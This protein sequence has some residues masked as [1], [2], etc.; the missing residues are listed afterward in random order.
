MTERGMGR[1]SL[2]ARANFTPILALPHSRNSQHP[3]A[4]PP[5][6]TPRISPSYPRPLPPG[7]ISPPLSPTTAADPTG[8]RRQG[9]GRTDVPSRFGSR[10]A[11]EEV[12]RRP[13]LKSHR[14]ERGVSHHPLILGGAPRSPSAG[15]LSGWPE[16][17]LLGLFGQSAKERPPAASDQPGPRGCRKS[18]LGLESGG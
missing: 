13:C 14:G 12:P 4:S 5:F 8:R 3:Q 17:A 11:T 9:W 6:P 16:R 18:P 7:V 15:S 10:L 2:G 1:F